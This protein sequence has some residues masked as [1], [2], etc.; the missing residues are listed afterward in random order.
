MAI[1]KIFIREKKTLAIVYKKNN[2]VIG[3]IGIEQYNEDLCDDYFNSFV[4][5]EIGYLLNKDYWNRG[6]MSEAVKRVIEYC[7]LELKL[8]FLFCGYFLENDRSCCVNE[9]MGFHQYKLYSFHTQYGCMKDT[10]LTLLL[11]KDFFKN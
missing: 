9:K 10:M 2:K 5:R 3:S 1:L 4:G 11:K 8:D 7:F 6:L